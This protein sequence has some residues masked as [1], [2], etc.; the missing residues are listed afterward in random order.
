[1]AISLPPV[2]QKVL[3]SDEKGHVTQPWLKW[4]LFILE[5]SGETFIPSDLAALIADLDAAQV[6]IDAL[7]SD[8][9]TLDASMLSQ[10]TITTD[11]EVR[12]A[13]L[14]SAGPGSEN[15]FDLYQVNEV[16]D[17]GGGITYVGKAKTDGT[18]LIEKLTEASGDLTKV[19]ANESN[20][21]GVSTFTDAW[22]DRATLTY[23]QIQTLTG[24]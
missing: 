19:Y 3:M 15:V 2:P 7:E 12:I 9:A 11:H 13:T 20:N 24:L 8:V 22:T 17:A 14:E 4:F 18:W 10:Q 1:M 6:D 16:D 5:R 21:S 23:G